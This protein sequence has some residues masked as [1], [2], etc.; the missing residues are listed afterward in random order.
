ML[1]T[2]NK[3][4]R[5]KICPVLDDCVCVYEGKNVDIES[6]NSYKKNEIFYK[7]KETIFFNG[8]KL[9]KVMTIISG[10]VMEY[11]LLPEGQRSIVNIFTPGD[12]IGFNLD[13][14]FLTKSTFV[15][16]T[17]LKCC[18]YDKKLLL[19]FVNK[20]PTVSSKIIKKL[21]LNVENMSSFLTSIGRTNSQSRICFLIY[22]LAKKVYKYNDS[23]VI[24][25]DIKIPL[26]QEDIADILGLTSVHV[27][28]SLKMLCEKNTISVS[29]KS[30]KIL[31]LNNINNLLHL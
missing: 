22:N 5:C 12:F 28:R 2:V 9:D 24:G 16:V 8:S 15:A 31:S 6:I 23:N 18:T 11:R 3:L 10:W 30:Y 19:G 29:K 4:D 25:K 17:D 27:S 26:S 7:K 14:N 13:N 21:T 20:T 1:K